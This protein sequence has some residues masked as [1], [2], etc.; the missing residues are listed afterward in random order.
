MISLTQIRGRHGSRSNNVR[1]N[2]AA[3][4]V[5]HDLQFVIIAVVAYSTKIGDADRYNCK[6]THENITFYIDYK[7]IKCLHNMFAALHYILLG[8]IVCD[9][10]AL[11]HVASGRTKS[12]PVFTQACR[13]ESRHKLLT[14]ARE[15]LIMVA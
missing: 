15:T 1:A 12:S 6:N 13:T 5:I 3:L 2:I 10:L 7:R 8:Q 9:H 14:D 4:S 11:W